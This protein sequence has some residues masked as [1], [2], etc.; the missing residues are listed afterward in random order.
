MDNKYTKPAYIKDKPIV[1]ISPSI[2]G[3]KDDSIYIENGCI[4]L[5]KMGFKIINKKDTFKEYPDSKKGYMQRAEVIN[6]AFKDKKVGGIICRSGGYGSKE[7][8]GFLNNNLIKNNP[9]VICGYSDATLL[10]LYIHEILK[11]VVFHGPT[12]ISGISELADITKQFFVKVF[13]EDSYPIKIKIG[14]E[15]WEKGKVT[16]K[17]IG[18]NLSKVI[19]HINMYPKSDFKDKI[20]FIEEKNES[21]DK[22]IKMINLLKEKKIFSKING[23][24]IGRFHGLD[25]NDVKKL[26][27]IIIDCID[28]P[29]PILYGFMSGHGENKIPLPFGTDVTID[30]SNNLVIY[31][32]CPFRD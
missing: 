14:L 17:V 3:K 31:E 27:D 12:L 20:L 25:E 30:A 4:E 5:K 16:T 13:A 10:L 32:E 26:K 1:F 7:V 6:N 2:K 19:E 29:I 21:F 23:L 11:Q 9:K 15:S 28:K 18:G 24:L 22:I 8:I